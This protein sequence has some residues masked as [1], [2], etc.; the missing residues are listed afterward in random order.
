MNKTP[1]SLLF[2][3]RRPLLLLLLLF[4]CCASVCI[5]QK[6]G[7]DAP[8]T[9]VVRELPRKGRSGVQAY[10][11]ATSKRQLI[12]IKTSMEDLK[13]NT[14]NNKSLKDSILDGD[15][16]ESRK[17]YCTN[18]NDTAKG[19]DGYNFIC[20]NESLLT[21]ER[22]TVLMDK[23]I[24]A[25]V[26]LHAERLLVD[27][28]GTPLIIPRFTEGACSLFTVPENHHNP[29]VE[30]ADFV[31]YVAAKPGGAF[32]ITCADGRS[33]RPIAGGLN[34]IP[35]PTASTRPNVR[36]AAHHIAHALGFDYERMKSLG[37]ISK[38]NVRGVERVVV[39]SNMTKKKA[40]EHYDCSDLEGMELDYKDSNQSVS[41][42]WSWRNAKD[43]LM[44]S[45]HALAGAYYTALTMAAF[46]DMKYYSAN[47]G[48]EEPMS[49]GNKSGCDFIRKGCL[50]DK[51]VSNYP[52]A[53]CT[54]E[55][56][57][58]SSDRFGIA[59]C[60]S[61]DVDEVHEDPTGSCP[62][63]LSPFHMELS[64]PLHSFPCTELEE[65]SFLGFLTGEN[66]MCLTTEDYNLERENGTEKVTE[67]MSG[68]CAQVLCDESNRKV[69]V[70]Y[71]GL[72][73]FQEC[74]E[75]GNITVSSSSAS[76]NFKTIYCPNYTE[77]CTVA[78]DGSSLHPLLNR[79]PY[80]EN[81]VSGAQGRLRGVRASV[82]HI[83][84]PRSTAVGSHDQGALVEGK[85]DIA[86]R[87]G[88][89]G[90]S[91]AHSLLHALLLAVTLV[92]VVSL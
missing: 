32:G 73:D 39:S 64:A 79:L 72:S 45:L 13:D 22:K 84:V 20:H 55:R 16:L 54:D 29:G 78:S 71:S 21:E 60:F 38:I 42:T 2:L 81:T 36:Q 15:N 7:G 40:Q 43:E 66:S 67:I 46:D 9:G 57:R 75:G 87:V 31:L 49:W 3:W 33:G 63:F 50:T 12:R 70:K 37:M 68:V 90:N 35:Y 51:G 88:M 17:N 34:F 19:M 10:T 65:G 86:H 85:K 52:N 11:V 48:M 23:I 83:V 25:A 76:L 92:V 6:D 8:S 74:P 18:T 53:F 58:C 41:S 27:P 91:A 30:K 82:N 4:L 80:A 47:W 28:E 14:L 1:H 61:V 44:S 59:R 62:V 26:Q 24:P 56:L 69:K 89:N 77:V 5:A